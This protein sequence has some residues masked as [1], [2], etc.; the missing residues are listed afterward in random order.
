MV[1]QVGLR[2]SETA[3]NL[4]LPVYGLLL[5]LGT[6]AV[7]PLRCLQVEETAIVRLLGGP[8]HSATL[9]YPSDLYVINR[10]ETD[11]RTKNGLFLTSA[12]GPIK[13][14]IIFLSYV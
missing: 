5:V 1:Q 13:K 2:T 14:R 11:I 9:A 3:L 12:N 8:G 10:Y 6:E 4:L 7:V